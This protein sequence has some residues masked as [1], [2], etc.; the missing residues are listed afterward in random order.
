MADTPLLEVKQIDSFY[1]NIQALHGVSLRLMPGEI[2]TLIGANG[3][4]KTST[5]RS[6][7]G[8]LRPKHGEIWF[9]G[10]RID[11][12]PAHK[13]VGRGLAMSPEG[14]RIFP[15]MTVLEMG[16]YLRTDT[17]KVKTDLEWVYELFPRIKERLPQRA[18]TL[19]GGEQQM[20]AIGRAL[21]SGPR[22]LLLAE[23]SLGLA[24]LV[25]KQIF[26]IIREIHRRGVSVLLV[27]QNARQALQV[28]HRAY[29]LETG[30]IVMEGPA[31]EL[32]Q[33]P[34]VKEAYLGLPA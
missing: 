22:L 30:K 29:L 17:A 32:A 12:L 18:G 1:G 11:G 26:E 5:L 9:A 14:R 24:P 34:K 7:T 3:A 13:L 23:P 16:S 4:G 8:L 15:R 20:L 6:I 19:S 2:L 10:E 25:V 33:D 21:L 31:A 28:A 27:E